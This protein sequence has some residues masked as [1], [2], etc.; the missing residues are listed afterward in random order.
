M[1]PV[2]DG[3]NQ[4]LQFSMVDAEDGDT[5]G[6]V[7]FDEETGLESA[8]VALGPGVKKRVSLNTHAL[9]QKNQVGFL[10]PLA[11]HPHPLSS[12]DLF[13]VTVYQNDL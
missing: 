5:L 2:L 1:G 9:Q 4:I 11:S 13:V 8:V 7:V 10:S 3:A 6:E 12:S